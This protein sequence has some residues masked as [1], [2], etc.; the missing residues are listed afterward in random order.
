MII[1]TDTFFYNHS[2]SQWITIIH[3]L[4]PNASSLTVEDSLHSRFRSATDFWSIE[5]TSFAQQWIYASYIEN[6]S[7]V[8]KNEC[9]MARYLAVELHVTLSY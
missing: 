3:N 7:S 8:V 2:Y 9:L 6:T 4:Q 1:F 5:N